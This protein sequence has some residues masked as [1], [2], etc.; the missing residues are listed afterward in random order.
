MGRCPTCGADADG[1]HCE[2]CGESLHDPDDGEGTDCDGASG[3]SRRAMLGYTGG[4]MAATFGVVGAGWLTFVYERTGPEEDVVREYVTALDRQHFNTAALLYHEDAPGTP[5]SPAENPRLQD[6]DISVEETAVTARNEDVEL[7]SVAQ[8]AF[9]DATLVFDSP[10][11]TQQ[12]ETGFVV[13]RRPEGE[14]RLWRDPS[15]LE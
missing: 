7:D 5:P 12:V 10:W 13:A 1:D 6:T 11:E 15:D 8:L 14:W 4:S 3:L 2:S 9:V